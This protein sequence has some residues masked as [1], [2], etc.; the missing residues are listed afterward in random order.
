MSMIN[1][2]MKQ[3]KYC[4]PLNKSIKRHVLIVDDGL[5]GIGAAA[6]FLKKGL[7]VVMIQK[8]IA[9]TKG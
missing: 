5:S 7:S 2:L 9:N 1:L 8:N 3:F 4:P 6:E